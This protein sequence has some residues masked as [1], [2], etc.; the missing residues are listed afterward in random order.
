MSARLIRQHVMITDIIKCTQFA[1][2]V[3]VYSSQVAE[4]RQQRLALLRLRPPLIKTE[5]ADQSAAIA[6]TPQSP[7]SSP[8][9][10]LQSQGNIMYNLLIALVQSSG[11]LSTTVY[12]G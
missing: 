1:N 11:E 6:L 3:N 8:R 2:T 5:V 7:L 9:P 4:S 10:S 12:P